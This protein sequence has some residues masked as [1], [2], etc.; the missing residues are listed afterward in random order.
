MF[1]TPSLAVPAGLHYA[2]EDILDQLGTR[3][4]RTW[5]RDTWGIWSRDDH[6]IVIASGLGAAQKGC[7]LAH[8]L[9]HALAGD[10]DCGNRSWSIRQE[11]R[12][13]VAAA[14][15]LIAIS[16]F[17][18]VAQWAPDIYTAAGELMVT[19]RLLEVRLND[20]RG[21]SWPWR[22]QDGLKIAG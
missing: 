11:R 2:P 7:V 18:E 3:I 5:L 12:A 8:E 10:I 19:E 20:L 14:C 4:V 17:A 13:D 6:S 1:T 21:E 16:D 22:R 15:K 9:E